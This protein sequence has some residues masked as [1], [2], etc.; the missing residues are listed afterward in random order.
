MRESKRVKPMQKGYVCGAALE[1]EIKQAAELFQTSCAWAFNLAEGVEG[2]VDI[3]METVSSLQKLRKLPLDRDFSRESEA[4]V[5]RLLRKLRTYS[6]RM[7]A[8]DEPLSVIGIVD[9]LQE[10]EMHCNRAKKL[11]QR[12]NHTKKL[13]VAKPQLRTVR[14]DRASER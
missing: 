6:R 11:L 13:K 2:F 14:N 1:L 7:A 12:N 9:D 10:L 3:F 4:D 5:R 8:E